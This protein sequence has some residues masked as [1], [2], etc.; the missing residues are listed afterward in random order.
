MSTL[1]IHIGETFADTKRRALA[2]IDRAKAGET[3]RENHLS[4][5]S[6]EVFTAT[7]TPKRLEL[8]RLVHREPQAS[9]AAL[10]RSLG[11]DY[12]RVH[13]DVEALAAAGVLVREE[14]ALRAPY[15]AIR[16]EVAL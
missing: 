4:F 6:W 13:E 12:K 2:A 10:A 14:G 1:E 8:V 9:I 16:A 11:R 7:M 5:A 15:D 3:V